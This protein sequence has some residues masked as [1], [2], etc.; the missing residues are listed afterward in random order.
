MMIILYL[1]T[2]VIANLIAAEF[3]PW[4]TVVNAFVFIGGTITVRDR[5]HDRWSK[6]GLT[7]RMA[8]LIVA[9]GAISAVINADA[10]RIA[11]AS[12]L[13]FAISESADAFTYHLL[14]RWPWL[15]RVNASNTVS[16]ALDSIL[17]PT[18]AFGA[19]MPTISAGHILAKVAGGFVWSLALKPRLAVA[20]ILFLFAVPG[21]SQILSLGAGTVTTEI[22]TEWTLEAYVASPPLARSR[23][24]SIL[25]R[26]E[27]ANVATLNLDIGVIENERWQVRP[28]LGLGW[29]S[30]ADYEKH[31]LASVTAIRFLPR[32]WKIVA[33]YSRDLDWNSD[34]LVLKFDRTLLFRK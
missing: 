21:S 31:N 15:K 13:S 11:I 5:L 29:F 4:G 16:S 6:R 30:F 1:S 24:Y 34:S 14:R 10:L 26:S 28:S 9:G 25:A 27:T 7:W 23:L 22:S 33:I 2:V 8:A 12:S 18:L 17:F 19:F 32:K 20:A 3:G